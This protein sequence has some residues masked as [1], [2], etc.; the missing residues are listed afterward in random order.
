MEALAAL[1]TTNWVRR[2][3][4]GAF[5]SSARRSALSGPRPGDAL[6]AGS[7]GLRGGSERSR[8][9]TTS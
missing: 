9:T 8:A 2:E 5:S 6:R 4:A 1:P 3:S 7:L